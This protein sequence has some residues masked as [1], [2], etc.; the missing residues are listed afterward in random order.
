MLIYLK[1]FTDCF[2]KI[3]PQLLE[4]IWLHILNHPHA[5]YTAICVCVVNIS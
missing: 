5:L 2:M 3:S 4:Q 1:L